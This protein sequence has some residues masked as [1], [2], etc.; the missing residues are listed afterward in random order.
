[1]SVRY[2]DAK[3]EVFP[4]QRRAGAS[5]AEANTD[6]LGN[7]P[8]LSFR[9]SFTAELRNLRPE[10]PKELSKM[11]SHGAQAKQPNQ[12]HITNNL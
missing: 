2:I 12:I 9:R 4:A 8:M 3:N 5:N 1:M 7:L 10:I 11:V 6:L